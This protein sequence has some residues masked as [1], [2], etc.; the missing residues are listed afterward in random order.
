[1]LTFVIGII[2]MNLIRILIDQF[3][4]LHVQLH[5]WVKWV[6]SGQKS[7]HPHNV[8]K[9]L[10]MIYKPT[11]FIIM[12]VSWHCTGNSS[13]LNALHIYIHIT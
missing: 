13:M 1:M 9:L 10:Q 12:I 6:H 2:I 3:G 4:A 7:K 11:Y 5:A 8:Q